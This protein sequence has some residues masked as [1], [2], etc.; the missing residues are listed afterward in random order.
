MNDPIL[1]LSFWLDGKIEDYPVKPIPGVTAKV[2]TFGGSQPSDINARRL[3][4]GLRRAASVDQKGWA[5]IWAVPDAATTQAQMNALSEWLKR[6][7]ATARHLVGLDLD[8]EEPWVNAKAVGR[9]SDGWAAFAKDHGLL[10][11]VNFVPGTREKQHR[12]PTS[13]LR[14]LEVLDAQ[15]VLDHAT[16]QFYEQYRPEKPWTKGDQFRPGV[17]I[18]EGFANTQAALPCTLHVGHM[19]AFRNHPAP[20]TQ[21]HRAT[22]E[23]L[24]AAKLCGAGGFALWSW[25]HQGCKDFLESR[26]TDTPDP[27]EDALVAQGIID[28]LGAWGQR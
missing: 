16:A 8:C 10:V 20:Y 18:R 19:A 13:V 5:T 9:A 6:E 11:S 1:P 21:G 4:A 17:W 23:A 22:R 3:S 7:S 24:I 12:V 28:N 25:K 15:K 26:I 14:L 2:I 27:E